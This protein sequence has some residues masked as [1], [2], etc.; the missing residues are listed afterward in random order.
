MT[1]LLPL[2]IGHHGQNIETHLQQ[3]IL[4]PHIGIGRG[5]H[6]TLLLHIH[7]RFGRLQR[8]AGTR[9]DLDEDQQA[10]LAGHD[11]Y[12]DPL[13]PHPTLQHP[14]P[15]PRQIVGRQVFPAQ[16]QAVSRGKFR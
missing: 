5:D 2:R 14:I 13:Y 7:R 10:I 16:P 9:F 8:I 15:A 11:V 3:K 6:T 12:L 4:L 1:D